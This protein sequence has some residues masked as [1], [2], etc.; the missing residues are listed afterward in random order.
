[1]SVEKKIPKIEIKIASPE[2]IRELSS[3]GDV[4]KYETYDSN[5]MPV[6]DGLFDYK[7]F[8]NQKICPEVNKLNCFTILNTNNSCAGCKKDNCL[9]CKNPK[10]H[11]FKQ[12]QKVANEC[13]KKCLTKK[14]KCSYERMGHIELAA[15][16]VH[17][18]YF[19]V[20]AKIFG[21]KKSTFKEILRYEKNFE[22]IEE[23]KKSI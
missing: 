13:C 23:L 14:N 11:D 7:I 16:I 12:Y 19:D 1:M 4:K 9:E 17:I 10:S 22:D 15:P 8:C 21:L 5:R 2:R 20:I 6:D 18:W 3:G